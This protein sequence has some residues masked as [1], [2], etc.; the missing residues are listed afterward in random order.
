MKKTRTIRANACLRIIFL[1][2]G[3]ICPLFFIQN[4]FAGE[5][6]ITALIA[7]L[8]HDKYEVREAATLK[9]L[10]LDLAA[11]NQLRRHLVS[12]TDLEVRYRASRIISAY[13]SPAY[14]DVG[15]IWNLPKKRRIVEGEDIALKYF[16]RARDRYN[17][18]SPRHIAENNWGDWIV[19]QLATKMYL[20]D[21][22]L[23][24]SEDKRDEVE[25]IKGEMR[26]IKS[27]MDE[28][29]QFCAHSEECYL[30]YDTPNPPKIA[31]DFIKE[32]A[33]SNGLPELLKKE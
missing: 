16:W 32:L 4:G 25:T 5:K 31:E 24:T 12:E 2:W 28:V 10:E 29:I 13:F 3:L 21:I 6:D 23:D 22:L 33:E 18:A 26:K 1:A 27:Q 14:T 17:E 11:I 15:M 8:G 30:Y 7:D 20:H 9:L 19:S